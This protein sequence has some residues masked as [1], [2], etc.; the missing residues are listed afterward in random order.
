[1]GKHNKLQGGGRRGGTGIR[2]Q[3]CGKISYFSKKDAQYAA[4]VLYPGDPQSPYE[5]R[6]A[7]E[8][9]DTR[10]IW[11]FGHLDERIKDGRYTR[12]V[13]YEGGLDDAPE[14]NPPGS[15]PRELRVIIKTHDAPAGT[16]CNDKDAGGGMATLGESAKITLSGF[17]R[18]NQ[19]RGI[20]SH[21][22]MADVVRLV[23]AASR[24][25]AFTHSFDVMDHRGLRGYV[26]SLDMH[27][28][29]YGLFGPDFADASEKF[30]FD[31]FFN[32]VRRVMRKL[33]VSYRV[34]APD[35]MAHTLP[36]WWVADSFDKA[37][38]RQHV[39]FNRLKGQKVTTPTKQEAPAKAAGGDPAAQDGKRHGKTA[40]QTKHYR[41]STPLN[42]RGRRLPTQVIER[43]YLLKTLLEDL[44]RDY[45]SA[46][47]LAEL[48]AEFK[49]RHNRE[50]TKVELTTAV[51]ALVAEKVAVTRTLSQAD[52]QAIRE[53]G[54][55]DIPLGGKPP[56]IVA[57]RSQVD[58]GGSIP[59]V[60]GTLAQL[61]RTETR[62]EARAERREAADAAFLAS[63]EV[64]QAADP[65][66]APEEPRA[67]T[68]VLAGGDDLLARA[69]AAIESAK[70]AQYERVTGSMGY[71]IEELEAMV[72]GLRADVDERDAKIA[73]LNEAL[74][75]L[76]ATIDAIRN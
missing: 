11:H 71:T 2:C 47:T 66:P 38:E 41:Q 48:L 20:T 65:V 26:G 56:I 32:V 70:A 60:L 27:E 8:W 28:L 43:M 74:E 12:D 36:I 17:D 18:E 23:H 33:D 69:Q 54:D 37:V 73:K 13:V 58:A 24:A 40:K 5:C 52:K 42:K 3:W 45:D 53:A 25:Y 75:G 76:L 4:R 68:G 7:P 10:C 39:V 57:L 31:D 29:V 22:E 21:S 49:S 9:V 34:N 63:P 64:V 67:L 14:W 30:D 35:H 55:P 59:T 46:Y 51:D 6:K 50:I 1:M 61:R 15:F 44:A 19:F 72:D 62:T 16:A